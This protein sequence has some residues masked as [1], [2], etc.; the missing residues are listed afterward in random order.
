MFME[1]W[2]HD[3][4]ENKYIC[5]NRKECQWIT[6]HTNYIAVLSLWQI[7]EIIN[8]AQSKYMHICL[9]EIPQNS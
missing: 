9:N 6:W 5:L 2:N 8:N 3:S 1:P 4:S 7:Q